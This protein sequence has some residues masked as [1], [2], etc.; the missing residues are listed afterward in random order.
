M[1][2]VPLIP[3]PNVAAVEVPQTDEHWPDV[4]DM[5]VTAQT[6]LRNLPFPDSADE[7]GR[8]ASD[9]NPMAMVKAQIQNYPM[10]R[11]LVSPTLALTTRCPPASERRGLSKVPVGLQSFGEAVD[12]PPSTGPHRGRLTLPPSTDPL[13]L[14]PPSTPSNYPLHRPLQ[15]TPSTDPIPL[16]PS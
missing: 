13:Q 16:P 12:G 14:P 7:C 10:H 2:T 6:L 5:T 1:E 11:V 8:W 3:L 15:L 4:S 9:E